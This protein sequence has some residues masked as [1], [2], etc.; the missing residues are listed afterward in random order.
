MDTE[1]DFLKIIALGI[2]GL[3]SIGYAI[4][5]TLN[6]TS[7]LFFFI[8]LALQAAILLYLLYIVLSKIKDAWTDYRWSP[9]RL[10]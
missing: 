10:K 6:D 4:K 3:I 1:R 5:L 2:L 9:D 8:F 7:G